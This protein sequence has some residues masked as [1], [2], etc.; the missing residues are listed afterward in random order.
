MVNQPDINPDFLNN[1]LIPTLVIAGTND[2]ITEEHTKLIA[3]S[4]PEAKLVF[5]KGNHFILSKQPE[6]FNKAVDEF[7]NE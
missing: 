6:A 5:I 7:L 3:S 4:I 1:I 2:L